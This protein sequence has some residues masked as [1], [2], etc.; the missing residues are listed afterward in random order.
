MS[1]YICKNKK[2][3]EV[4]GK[5]RDIPNLTILKCTSCGL[6]YL[7]NFNHIGEHYY[8]NSEM[9]DYKS[10]EDYAKSCIDND[11]W[12]INKYKKLF[13]NKVIL[14]FG[15]GLGGFIEGMLKYT[16]IYGCEID[17]SWRKITSNISSWMYKNIN[18][19]PDKRFDY[20]TLF[21]VLE[22]LKNPREILEKIAPKLKK[23]GIIIV[24]VPNSDDA[25]LTLYKC[26]AFQNFTYW[27]CHLYLFNQHN[28]ERLIKQSGLKCSHIIQTQRYPLSNHMYWLAKGK[29]GGHK[30][31]NCL[32]YNESNEWYENKLAKIGKCDTL[33]A[34][35][36]V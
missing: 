24:E 31:W 20:I 33:V 19:V 3:S 16:T 35:V 9:N 26:E 17:P 12:R 13:R 27:G 2:T 11:L 14:D 8:K 18:E 7:E 28:L 4:K 22:H 6:V 5:V 34:L 10:L 30:I 32:D 1:C 23:N 25:L 15:S 21:H 36:K 29:P